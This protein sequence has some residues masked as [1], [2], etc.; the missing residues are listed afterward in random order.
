MNI[1]SSV[2]QLL[3]SAAAGA[4]GLKKM[5][6]E[7][8]ARLTSALSAQAEAGQKKINAFAAQHQDNAEVQKLANLYTDVKESFVVGNTVENARANGNLFKQ[9]QI[10]KV[11]SKMLKQNFAN[12]M[13][14][15]VLNQMQARIE[16]KA[17]FNQLLYN[18]AGKDPKTGRFVSVKEKNN[19]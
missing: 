7:K 15:D 9:H 19:G 12:N 18:G 5:S 11:Y 6:S 1:Q 2:N 13:A 8:G 10:N 14:S 3:G 16:Q 4:Y 17:D